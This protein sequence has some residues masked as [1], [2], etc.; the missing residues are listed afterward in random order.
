MA[1][2]QSK[3]EGAPPL[4]PVAPEERNP[5]LDV[6]R[7]FALLGIIVMNMPGFSVPDGIHALD[8]H[9]FPRF[10]DRAAETVTSIV[11][12]GKANSIFSFLFGLGLTVQMQR[13][14]ASG[15]RLTPLYLRRVAV[16]FLVGAAHAIFL[17][18]GDVLHTYAVL[19]LFLLALRRASDRLVFGLIAIAFL[20]PTVRSMI[21]LLLQEAP[22]HPRS[23]WV[24]MAH[25]HMRIYS[26]GTYLEQIGAR[27][28]V[29]AD[30]YAM[31]RIGHGM[32]WW[33]LSVFVT[34]L[35]GLYAGKKRLLE[36]VAENLPRIRKV[37][38]ISLS[39]GI[40]AS[41]GFSLLFEFR[42]M[43]PPEGWT[44][45]GFFAELLFR[46]N[47]PLLCIA[48]IAAIALL[49]QTDRGKRVLLVLASPGRM[50]LTNYLTQSLIAT[51]LFYSYGFGW[52]GKVGPLLG[53]GIAVA[54]FA[55]QVVWSR[56]WLARFRYGPL[57]WLWRAATYGKLPPMRLA[58]TPA[59]P[60][61][62]SPTA[63]GS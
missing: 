16:L 28:A 60:V 33:Y 20:A 18:N 5:L 52:Y 55:V 8:E 62:V 34:M 35:L 48:Y 47:R 30:A 38:W 10:Y 27:L 25:E 31:I 49:L 32:I 44:W 9:Y 11:F 50:P 63:S 53:T 24:A 42:P 51:T 29:F 45:Y 23:F 14:E 37:L 59:A 46:V 41:V 1:E 43:P 7:G 40:A 56:F 36:D 22:P 3:T 39:L 6:L 15:A 4:T 57:E 21:G 61:P 26:T 54:I 19:G 12:A 17:W 2:E 13:A 58:Q